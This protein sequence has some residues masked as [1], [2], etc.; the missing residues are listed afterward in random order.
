MGT[1]VDADGK[2]DRAAAASRIYK[3]KIAI[4]C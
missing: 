2:W 4:L 1:D 3:L